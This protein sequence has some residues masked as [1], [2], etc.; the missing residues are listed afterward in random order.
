MTAS[1]FAFLALG[2][3]LGLA[4]GAALIEIIRAR[5]P[6]T[7]EVRVTVATDAIPRRRAATLADDAFSEPLTSAEPARGGPADRR[8]E[9]IGVMPDRD[10]RRTPVLEP[11]PGTI[12]EPAFRLA[13]PGWQDPQAVPVS[14]GHDPMLTALRSSA[15]ASAV[16]AM[17]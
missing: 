13:D 1:E 2:L 16:A 5:P 17:R 12:V 6:S 3:I 14:G 9:P 4:A 15:A 8:Q 10:D 11:R 7:R